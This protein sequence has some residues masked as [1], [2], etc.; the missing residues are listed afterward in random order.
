MAI[1]IGVKI[2][3]ANSVAVAASEQSWEGA[4]SVETSALVDAMA[5][6]CLQGAFAATQKI[7]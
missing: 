6:V 2:G 4:V 5:Q 1:G 7:T 3:S